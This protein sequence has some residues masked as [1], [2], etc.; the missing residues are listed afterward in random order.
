MAVKTSLPSKAFVSWYMG[1][2]KIQSSGSRSQSFI[3]EEKESEM[4]NITIRIVDSI[5]EYMEEIENRIR[6][7]AYEKFLGRAD[8]SSNDLED[9]CAAE[10]ELICIVASTLK[11]D[12]NSII[13]EIEIPGRKV[14]MLE[15]QATSQDVILHAEI[16]NEPRTD[17][18]AAFGVIRFPSPID[19]AGLRAE[20]SNGLLRLT[21]PLLEVKALKQTA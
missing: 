3:A 13:G 10:H 12:E 14:R 18:S 19:A 1:Q 9:W 8:G 5:S 2:K 6:V 16:Q 21:A 15:I 4:K 17:R 7:R 11:A 20:F